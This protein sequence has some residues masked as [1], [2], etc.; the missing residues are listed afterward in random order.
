MT[1]K[2]NQNG[3][4]MKPQ[5]YKK[6]KKSHIFQVFERIK[7]YVKYD[8]KKKILW[9]HHIIRNISNTQNLTGRKCLYD[10]QNNI[11]KDKFT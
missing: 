9:E 10:E 3:S 4:G 7:Y 5:R 2:Q 11:F 8:E 6:K 1:R